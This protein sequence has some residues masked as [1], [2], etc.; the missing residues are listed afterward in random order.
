[1]TG[2]PRRR[3]VVLKFGG[4]ALA[5]PR[6]VV[7]RVRA[8]RRRRD[9]VVVA[10][11]REGVTES[12]R[13]ALARPLSGAVRRRALARLVQDHPDL[14][15]RGNRV[16]DRA[17]RSLRRLGSDPS[18]P[19]WVAEELLSCG[20]R[21]AVHWLAGGLRRAGMR[22]EPVEADRLGLVTDGA[23][24]AAAIQVARSSGH[25]R[26][27]LHAILEEGVVPVVTG[28][29]GR[30]GRGRVATLGPGGSD[31][32]AS[33]LAAILRA[34]RVELIKRHLTVRTADPALVPGSR[35]LRELSYDDAEELA[36]SGARILHPLTIGPARSQGV[37]LV[38]RPLDDPQALTR[39]GPGT[40][41]PPLRATTLAED[42]VLLRLRF[43]G[44]E[45]RPGV[46]AGVTGALAAEGIPIGSLF[47]TS[48]LLSLVLHRRD[49][50]RALR[51]IRPMLGSAGAVA[52][53]PVRVGLVSVIGDGVLPQI[54]R[55]PR[56][57]M[58]GC[59]GLSATAR[60]A[61]LA[62]PA[63]RARPALR[64][65]HRALLRPPGRSSRPPPGA[66]R[67]HPQRA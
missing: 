59:L 52:E 31:Y 3:V 35:A 55:L 10:S 7:A 19:P 49:G 37:L 16:L 40:S 21:L 14:D 62:F 43:P 28:F 65:L 5:D 9:V 30:T 18:A 67:P 34:E 63:A 13:E 61:R 47:T 12:L 1:M 15:R 4:A 50:P 25:V 46:A 20:E 27:R 54:C 6:A 24:G 44:G 45:G 53:R 36:Q 22:A 51:R 32:T 41:R 38:V 56:R 11:A 66:G 23:Y 33:A 64:A 39:I 26:R 58:S 42:R 60:S 8:V 2:R 48:T 57:A 17:R 29:F